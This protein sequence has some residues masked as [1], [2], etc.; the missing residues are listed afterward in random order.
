MTTLLYDYKLESEYAGPRYWNYK[1]RSNGL[2]VDHWWGD[3]HNLQFHPEVPIFDRR[4][5]WEQVDKFNANQE[6]FNWVDYSGS[7]KT[8]E[9][10]RTYGEKWAVEFYYK[11]DWFKTITSDPEKVR[12]IYENADQIDTVNEQGNPIRLPNVKITDV[13]NE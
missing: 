7:S 12:R 3:V 4:V 1:V 5:L 8:K 11:G 9:A 6:A 2:T 13:T 10:N